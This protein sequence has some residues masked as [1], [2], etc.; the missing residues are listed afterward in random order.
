MRETCLYVAKWNKGIADQQCYPPGLTV[1]PKC[2]WR[3]PH[4][5]I[6]A[7]Q[8]FNNRAAAHPSHQKNVLLSIPMTTLS[9]WLV[10]G[11]GLW[12]GFPGCHLFVSGGGLLITTIV[13]FNPM[14]IFL[15]SLTFHTRFC[16]NGK[17]SCSMRGRRLPLA[18]APRVSRAPNFP[19][20]L[21]LSSVCHA[22]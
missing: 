13:A 5:H 18:L 4:A 20:F 19:L 11:G 10:Q 21:P 6:F 7:F 2:C 14:L 8:N 15:M 17:I 9:M 12:L 16:W 3:G 22:R 1:C